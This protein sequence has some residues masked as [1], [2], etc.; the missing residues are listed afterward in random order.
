MVEIYPPTPKDVAIPEKES[1]IGD[2]E[3]VI[4]VGHVKNAKQP[5][6]YFDDI[7][8]VEEPGTA[9]KMERFL[10]E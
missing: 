10:K 1:T 9:P 3:K 4:P 5:P 7:R 2:K 6:E 8:L